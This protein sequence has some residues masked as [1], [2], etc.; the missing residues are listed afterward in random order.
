MRADELNDDFDFSAINSINL[1]KNN[2]I[3]SLDPG[4]ETMYEGIR[5]VRLID[6]LLS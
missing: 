3:H 5:S 6:W 4:F 2:A 1:K